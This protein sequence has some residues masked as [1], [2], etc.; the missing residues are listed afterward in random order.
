MVIGAGAAGL[1][2]ARSLASRSLRV[3]VLE[4]RDRIG[5]RVF[6]HQIASMPTRAELGAEFIHGRAEQTMALLH[7]AGVEA[8]A[9]SGELWMRKHGELRLA[10]DDFT[11]SAAIFEG[12]RALDDDESVDR[13]LR[14]FA[15][16]QAMRETVE[17]ARSFVEGFDGADPSIASAL[18]IAQ[19][20]GSGVDA[21]TARPLGGYQRMFEYL[22]E[23]CDAMGVQMSL[24]TIVRRISWRRGAVRVGTTNEPGD[25]RTIES[26][27]AVVTLPVGV[28]R[29]SGDK[30]AVEFDP[31]LPSAKCDA[32]GSIE[33]G[34]VIKVALWFRTAFWEQICNGRY[35]GGAFF[36]GE[37]QPFA[38]Y[39][40][41]LPVR[42]RLIVA[43][44]GGPKALALSGAT[45]TQLVEQAVNGFGSLFGD[46]AVARR[47]F[48][49]GAVHDWDRDP[50]ARGAYSYVAVGGAGARATLAAP[51]DKTLFF[52]G[53]ATSGDGQGGTVNG[54]LETGERAAAEVL[55]SLG[56]QR[57]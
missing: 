31:G 23:A 45:Q 48:E 38:V 4:G 1:A 33:M 35:R 6:S 3:V 51:I 24:S 8:A 42:S 7:E 50:F 54:A 55:T 44:V 18:A 46:P 30:V 28:L 21:T 25:S 26:R 13:F 14:R 32:L 52:A 16:D 34:H 37:G 11:S 36:S 17:T 47:E 56:T 10:V 57:N 22:R 39:W 19:E 53:E 5:G 40:S 12:A 43:W 29:Q 2:A 20:W 41:Q 15:G 49:A 27:A 9:T